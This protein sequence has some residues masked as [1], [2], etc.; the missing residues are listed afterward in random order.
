MFTLRFACLAAICVFTTTISMTQRVLAVGGEGILVP[1]ENWTVLSDNPPSKKPV[2][3][4]ANEAPVAKLP[5]AVLLVPGMMHGDETMTSIRMSLRNAKIPVAMFRYDS[6][7]GAD[8]VATRLATV[9]AAEAE[10]LPH[11]DI[12]LVT[13]SMGGVVARCVVESP[14]CRIKNVSDLIMIAPPNH[15]SSLAA[16]SGAEVQDILQTFENEALKTIVNEESIGLLNN[17]LSLF[18]GNAKIDLSP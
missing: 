3:I 4:G 10:R 5:P 18:L 12:V 17:T 14:Q 11:R 1:L 8:R 9:L 7:L 6:Q 15:G 16:L 13:H 2:S